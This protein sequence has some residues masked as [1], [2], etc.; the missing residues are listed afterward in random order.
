MSY[1]MPWFLKM[2]V[3][4][5]ICQHIRILNT[6]CHASCEEVHDEFIRGQMHREITNG[7][8]ICF[9]ILSW[10]DR[11][12]RRLQPKSMLASSPVLACENQLCKFI[13]K[14]TFKF[15]TLSRLVLVTMGVVFRNIGKCYKTGCFFSPALFSSFLLFSSELVDKQLPACYCL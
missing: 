4:V 2:F 14:M 7:L 11:F 15:V 3:L 5:E 1:N 8:P 12:R 6:L 13:P 9:S 10:L